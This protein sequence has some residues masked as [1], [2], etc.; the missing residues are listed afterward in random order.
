MPGLRCNV[1]LKLRS[2]LRLLFAPAEDPRQSYEFAFDHQRQFLVKVDHAL[3]DISWAKNRL[4]A[5]AA[6]CEARESHLREQARFFMEDDQ[7][8]LAR[9]AIQRANIAATEKQAVQQQ[10]QI[11]EGDE[12]RLT[13]IEQQLK[14]LLEAY[15][16]RQEYL[17]TRHN[18]AEAQVQIGEA[19]TGVSGELDQLGRMLE[20][21]EAESEQILAR[22]A[23]VGHLMEDSL[24]EIA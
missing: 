22:A 20:S 13:S 8:D 24:L 4:Q 9:L 19:L 7:E 2:W 6:E 21:A 23:A 15:Y 18:A 17:V 5:K 12:R 11:I 10:L 1:V 16:A 14:A 3:K